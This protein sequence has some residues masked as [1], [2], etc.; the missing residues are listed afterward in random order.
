MVD[1]KRLSVWSNAGCCLKLS[2]FLYLS[3]GGKKNYS[4]ATNV[5]DIY[6]MNALVLEMVSVLTCSTAVLFLNT[7]SCTVPA[8]WGPWSHFLSF[9]LD[10]DGELGCV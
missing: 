7:E 1:G 5:K 4:L 3:S 8:N 6:A 10:R 2:Q 9:L